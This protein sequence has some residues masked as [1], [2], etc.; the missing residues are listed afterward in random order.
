MP[1]GIFIDTD[2]FHTMLKWHRGHKQ[3]GDISFT[4]ERIAEGMA[5]G[6]SVEIDLVCHAGGGMAVLH[7]ELLDK[8]TTGVGPVRGATADQLRKLFL[9][10]TN[11]APSPH[12]IMLIEDLARLLADSA[13]GKGAVLQLDLKEMVD[14]L[15]E[16]DVAAFAAAIA[17]VRDKVILSA[18]DARAV[19]RLAEAVPGLP[20]GYDPCHDGAIER[21]LASGDFAGFVDMALQAIPEA[22]T[23]YLHHQ[24]VLTAE[25]RGFDLIAAFH[26]AGKRIDAYTI[27]EANPAS[28]AK[29]LRLLALR[30]DQI[31]TDDPVGLEQ[32]VLNSRGE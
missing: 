11:G 32:L 22:Q 19:A 30:C 21:V 9:R 13:C 6:A 10:D 3:A 1:D 12:R 24:L 18:G 8:A 20:V 31:T 28:L 7:D 4:P 14:G 2:G 17:P 25:D 26:A 16:A 29:V 27:Q 23:I 5:R 15:A